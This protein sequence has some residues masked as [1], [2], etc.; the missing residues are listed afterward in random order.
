MIENGRRV[1]IEYTLTLDD[2]SVADSNVGGEPLVYQQGE[3][4]ILP[5][6]EDALLG[7]EEN[8][9]RKVTLSAAQGYGEVDPDLLRPVPA[10]AVPEEA[11]QVGQQLLAQSADGQ[12]RPVRVHEIRGDEIVIDMNHPLAGQ[13][14]H[15]EIRVLG[16][17]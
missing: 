12:R 4:Q 6:L 2:G 17:E 15:F 9:S 10:S 13:N 5:A 1:S 14:L 7:M 3:R 16:I 11:R 8:E